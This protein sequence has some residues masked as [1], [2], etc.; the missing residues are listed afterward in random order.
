MHADF[1]DETEAF[2]DY[3]ENC[4]FLF[5]NFFYSCVNTSTALK[6]AGNIFVVGHGKKITHYNVYEFKLK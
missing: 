5:K 6:K 2:Y 3:D 4:K 1:Y